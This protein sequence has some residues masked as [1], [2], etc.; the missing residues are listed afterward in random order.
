MGSIYIY[1]S[2]IRPVYS[3]VQEL[4]GERSSRIELLNNQDRA[5]SLV[6]NL[7]SKYRGLSNVED[8]LSLILPNKEGVPTLIN[9]LQVIA[10]I[11]NLSFDSSSLQY[12]ALTQGGDAIISPLGTIRITM[13]LRGTYDNF[14][15]YLSALETNNRLIDLNS[16]RIEGGGVRGRDALTYNLVVDSYYQAEQ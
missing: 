6:N 3:E 16:L 5:T 13:V 11:N 10:N 1:L 15:K 2:L 12:L 9:Q 7:L 4:R 8:A 14:K